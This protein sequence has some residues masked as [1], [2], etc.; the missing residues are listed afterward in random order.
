MSQLQAAAQNILT[1]LQELERELQRY[2]HLSRNQIV[3]DS[4]RGDAKG[5]MRCKIRLTTGI[6]MIVFFR[7]ISLE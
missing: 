6:L 7:F 5:Q 4:L 3:N 1:R 2:N